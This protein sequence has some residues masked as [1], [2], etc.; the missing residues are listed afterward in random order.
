MRSTR[1]VRV[2]LTLHGSAVPGWFVPRLLAAVAFTALPFAGC[3]F[4]GYRY[5]A[6]LR[7]ATHTGWIAFVTLRCVCCR[8]SAPLL[9][10][11]GLRITVGCDATTAAATHGLLVTTCCGYGLR[12]VTTPFTGYPFTV[13]LLRLHRFAILPTARLRYRCLCLPTRPTTLR[14]R[15]HVTRSAVAGYRFRS[16]SYSSYVRT[17]VTFT[18]TFV[19]VCLVAV[20]RLRFRCR[21]AAPSARFHARTR[22]G[23]GSAHPSHA[24]VCYHFVTVATLGWITAVLPGSGWFTTHGS[25]LLDTRTVGSARYRYRYAFTLHTLHSSLLPAVVLPPYTFTATFSSATSRGS[26]CH[27]LL[28]CLTPGCLVTRYT[29]TLDVRL[30]L[31]LPVYLPHTVCYVV[32][33]GY[34]VVALLRLRC[35]HLP[36]HYHSLPIR[37]LRYGYV[38]YTVALHVCYRSRIRSSAFGYR[39]RSAV[40]LLRGY[41]CYCRYRLPAWLYRLPFCH[42]LLHVL[43]VTHIRTGYYTASAV[44]VIHVLRCVRYIHAGYGLRLLPCVRCG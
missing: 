36:H 38:Y 24:T 32:T 3:A 25:A 30:R 13:A 7:I 15:P 18:R 19:Y 42:R 43:A 23:Y 17:V 16:R 5:V 34:I 44:A 29:F 21:R 37:L 26:T 6:T 28:P 10:I 41:V 39:Y 14:L 1:S 40:I 8:C 22:Y 35:A 33:F 31:R 2:L 9:Y 4:T 12:V 11:T 20:L 27:H